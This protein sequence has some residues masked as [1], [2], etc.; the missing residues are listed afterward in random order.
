MK[1]VLSIISVFLLIN[2]ANGGL[3]SWLSSAPKVSN[4][5]NLTLLTINVQSRTVGGTQNVLLLKGVG[6]LEEGTLLAYGVWVV[7]PDIQ[8]HTTFLEN[9]L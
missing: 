8:R 5:I 9:A 7:I 4:L 1:M 3:L 2:I 6:A